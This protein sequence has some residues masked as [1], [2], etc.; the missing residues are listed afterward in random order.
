MNN[1]LKAIEILE[2]YSDL[3]LNQSNLNRDE[4]QA[5]IK[6]LM[7]I[8]HY[9]HYTAGCYATDRPDLFKSQI[10]SELMFQLD[11]WNCLPIDEPAIIAYKD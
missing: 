7:D 1:T 8:Q 5:A 11:F 6:Q 9:T 2:Q 3:L 10:G 4:L